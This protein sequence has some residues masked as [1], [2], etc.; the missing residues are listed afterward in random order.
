[1]LH[2][3]GSRIDLKSGVSVNKIAAINRDVQNY[4]WDILVVAADDMICV[5]SNWDDQ[6]RDEFKVHFPD[7]NGVI[8]HNDNHVGNKLNTMP[9]IG[10]RYFHQVLDGNIYHPDYKSLWADNEFTIVS[11]KIG[12][13]IYIDDVLFDH[14][15]PLWMHKPYDELMKRNEAL[16]DEDKITFEKRMA[17]NFDLPK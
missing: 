2:S 3:R 7:L 16:H 11:V 5:R 10:N 12:K 4:G 8:W 15:H 6:I 1:M 17:A 9:I 13:T 14:Q